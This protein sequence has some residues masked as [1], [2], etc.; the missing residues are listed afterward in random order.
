MAGICVE[1][2]VNKGSILKVEIPARTVERQE[3]R[4]ETK[5]MNNKIET[6]KIEF[7]DIYS[8]N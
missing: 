6:I 2:E 7:S 8:V 4:E 3:F 1:S 5:S